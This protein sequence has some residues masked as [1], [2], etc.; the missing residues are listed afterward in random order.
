MIDPGAIGDLAFVIAAYAVILGGAG[1]YALT[2]A[3]RLRGA[4]QTTSTLP[5]DQPRPSD[6]PIDPRA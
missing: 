1:L 3:R 5:L 6:P 2:L 4:R